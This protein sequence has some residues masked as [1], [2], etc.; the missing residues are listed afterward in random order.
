MKLTYINEH[1]FLTVIHIF[2]LQFKYD[3]TNIKGHIIERQIRPVEVVDGAIDH[4][5]K[6]YEMGINKLLII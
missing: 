2:F 1:N 5:S 3:I 4:A 6:A